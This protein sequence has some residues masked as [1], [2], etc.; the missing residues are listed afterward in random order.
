MADTIT[1]RRAVTVGPQHAGKRMSLERFARA[2]PMPGYLYELERGVVVVSNIPRVSHASIVGFLR[3]ELGIYWREHRDSVALVSGSN[4]SG[5]RMWE[6]QSE[7]HPDVTIY[8]SPPPGDNEQVWDEWTPDIVIE[9]ISKQS[10]RRDY[11]V[12]P[13]DYLA[14]GVRQYWIVDPLKESATV[15]IRRGDTWRETRYDRRGVI[16]TPL[17]PGFSLRLSEVFAAA[18]RG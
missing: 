7:R 16:R 17:L 8:L 6:L 13:R 1:T 18:K 14:A 4:D 2:E 15:L 11:E 3:T 10:R 12:K 5:L 9:V